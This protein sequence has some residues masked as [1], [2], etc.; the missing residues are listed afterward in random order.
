[1]ENETTK[2]IV[3]FYNKIN[4]MEDWIWI[5]N[6]LEFRFPCFASG[7]QKIGDFLGV[8]LI[9]KMLNNATFEGLWSVFLLQQL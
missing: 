7:S 5:I 6:R 1:M 4:Q 9:V 8:A 3:D 2:L